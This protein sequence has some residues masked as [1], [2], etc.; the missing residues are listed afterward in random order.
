MQNLLKK[1][2]F[3]SFIRISLLLCREIIGKLLVRVKKTFHILVYW[4]IHII[5]HGRLLLRY[6]VST[7]V[8]HLEEYRERSLL[9]GLKFLIF[10]ILKPSTTNYKV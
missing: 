6:S 2:I 7:K 3:L 4:V 8:S 10:I 1:Y 9:L 5:R